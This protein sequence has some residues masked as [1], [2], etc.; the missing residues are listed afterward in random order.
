VQDIWTR[1]LN[2]RAFVRNLLATNRALLAKQY[3]IITQFFDQHDIAYFRGGN[4]AI[5]VWADFRKRLLPGGTDADFASSSEYAEVLFARQ[6]LFHERCQQKGVWISK[7]QSF[8][9]EEIGWFRIVF[10]VKEETLKVGLGRI[11]EAL[12]ELEATDQLSH[13][14]SVRLASCT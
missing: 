3:G 14:S 1:F 11:V 7:G 9:P 8:T 5:F 12:E 2:D 6:D 10:T 13:I 4:A